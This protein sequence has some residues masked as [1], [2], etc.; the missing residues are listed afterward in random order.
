MVTELAVLPLNVEFQASGAIRSWRARRRLTPSLA[1][2]AVRQAP[3]A[4]GWKAKKLIFCSLR[5][6]LSLTDAGS[7]RAPTLTVCSPR[8]TTPTAWQCARQRLPASPTPRLSL[9]SISSR[10]VGLADRAFQYPAGRRD[11]IRFEIA[12]VIEKAKIDGSRGASKGS[13]SHNP[14]DDLRQSARISWYTP[15]VSA[16]PAAAG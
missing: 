5:R 12:A 1:A 15:A 13:G 6:W 3:A 7:V 10:A 11:V 4:A 9:R 8:C 2:A 16:D 14:V